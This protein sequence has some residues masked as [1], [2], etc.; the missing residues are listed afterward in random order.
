MV[1][2]LVPATLYRFRRVTRPARV[3]SSVG[4][5]PS[6]RWLLPW[7]AVVCLGGC[8]LALSGPGDRDRRRAAGAAPRC[9]TG[10]GLVGL[11]GVLGAAV[12]IGALTAFGEDVPEVGVI[13]GLVSAAFIASAF[14]GNRV[15]DECRAAFAEHSADFERPRVARQP[16][17]VED[18][19][20]G[21]PDAP[22]PALPLAGGSVPASTTSADATPPIAMPPVQPPPVTTSPIAPPPASTPAPA[23]PA[24]PRPPASDPWAEFWKEVP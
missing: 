19:V 6:R 20:P 18:Q 3:R 13:A 22:A 16:R 14:R 17:P 8:S 15:V 7:L 2:S 23:R 9:D 10:K 12:G 1:C 21:D 11:D 24:R 5:E 4:V